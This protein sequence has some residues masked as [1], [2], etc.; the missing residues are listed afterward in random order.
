M[1]G[2][3]RCHQIEVNNE[4]KKEQIVELIDQNTNNWTFKII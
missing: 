4:I 3:K 1:N 2:S